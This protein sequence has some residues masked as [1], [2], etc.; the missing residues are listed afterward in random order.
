[1]QA[2][3]TEHYIIR[4]TVGDFVTSA[5]TPHAFHQI[6]HGQGQYLARMPG[7][8]SDGYPWCVWAKD[9]VAYREA[10]RAREPA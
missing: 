6:L 9:V 7:D 1:M 8:V 3:N 10:P 5:Y 4:T 2:E